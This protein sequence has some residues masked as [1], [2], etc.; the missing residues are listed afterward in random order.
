LLDAGLLSFEAHELSKIPRGVIGYTPYIRR[1]IVN[2]RIMI[3]QLK[4]RGRSDEQIKEHIRRKY[5][6]LGF[7]WGIGAG[8]WE[9]IRHYEDAYRTLNPEYESPWQKRGHR[10]RDFSQAAARELRERKAEVSQATRDW[11]EMMA[12]ERERQFRHIRG[13]EE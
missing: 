4:R 2:R 11:Q 13:E 7:A 1:F 3:T 6:K 10:R 5:R 8:A 12:R 9:Y